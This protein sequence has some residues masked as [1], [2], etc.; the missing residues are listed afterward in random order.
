MWHRASRSPLLAAG[1][2][3]ETA[4]SLA[5]DRVCVSKDL[6]DAVEGADMVQDAVFESYE[7]TR[8]VAIRSGAWSP[9]RS[10]P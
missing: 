10:I 4:D 3:P 8:R 7:A 6:E 2:S 5:A 9:I 1:Q